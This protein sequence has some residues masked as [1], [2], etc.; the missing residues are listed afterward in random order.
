M[1]IKY[2]AESV[3]CLSVGRARAKNNAG[4]SPEASACSSWAARWISIGLC[5]GRGRWKR[6]ASSLYAVFPEYSHVEGGVGV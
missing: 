6:S 4:E 1:T 2:D 5:C 3:T